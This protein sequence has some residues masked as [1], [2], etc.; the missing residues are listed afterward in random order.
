MGGE[1]ATVRFIGPKGA[2]WIALCLSAP[3]WAQV[4]AVDDVTELRAGSVS[5]ARQ[6]ARQRVDYAFEATAGRTYLIEL[7]QQGL[8]FVLSIEDPRGDARTYGSPLLRDEREI[9]LL[10]DAQ[11]GI[12]RVSVFSEEFS[13]ASGRH[14]IRLS[15]P[16]PGEDTRVW[17]AMSAG[18]AAYRRGGEQGWADAIAA[19][20][21][22]AGLA[23]ESG[24][25]REVAHALFGIAAIEYWYRYAWTRAAELAKEAAQLYADLDQPLLEASALHLRAAALIEEA[26]TVPRTSSAGLAPRARALF[27]EALDL[28]DRVRRTFE[29]RGRSYEAGLAIN[30]VG[31]T[32]YYMGEYAAA[33]ASWDE[34]AR[35]FRRLGEWDKELTALGNQA[36]IAAEQGRLADAIAIFERSLDLLSADHP[37]R[38]LTLDNLAATHYARGDFDDA[39]RTFSAALDLHRRNDDGKGE[40]HALRGIGSTYFALGHLELAT[41]FLERALPLARES[42]DGRNEKSIRGLL[43]NV[44]FLEGEH[45]EALN[46][47]RAALALATA[48]TDAAVVQVLLAKDLV[49]LGRHAAAGAL[50]AEARATAEAAGAKLLVADAL[51][52]SGQARL[53]LGRT[54]EAAAEFRRALAVYR[55]LGVSTKESEA[56]HGIAESAAADGRLDDA[57]RYGNASLVALEAERIRIAAPELRA[58]YAAIRRGYYEA[59]IERLMTLH[60][61]ARGGETDA[62]L[63]AAFETSE[64]SRAR[65]L[66][67]LM[68]ETA[69]DDTATA[70]D[71]SARERARLI[72]R[73]AGLR[74]RRDSLLAAPPTAQTE[75]EVAEAVAEMTVVDNELKVLET[76]LRSKDERSAL[77]PASPLSLDEIQA[78]LD[79]HSFLVQYALGERRSHAWIVTKSA[80]HAVELAPREALESAAR[81]AHDALARYDASASRTEQLEERL[82]SLAEAVLAPVRP[83]LGD[84]GRIVFSADGALQYVPFGV[85]RDTA[86]DGR[87]LIEQYEIAA[88]P[89]VS[90]V[91]SSRAATRPEIAANRVAVIADPV[92]EPDDARL[93]GIRT[94]REPSP[95]NPPAELEPRSALLAEP[96]A[97]LPFAG[98]EASAIAALVPPD[99]RLVLTGVAASRDAVLNADLGLYRFVHFATHGFV[100]S[101]YPSLSGL[102]LSGIDEHGAPRDGFLRLDDIRV[103]R[104]DADVVVL[105]ACETALGREIRGEGLL[106]LTHAFMQAGARSTVASLWQVPDRATAELMSRFYAGMLERGLRPTEALRAAQLEIAAERRWRDPYFW[107]AFVL[108]GDWR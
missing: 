55:E 103:L 61:A 5:S 63:L 70:D 3:C 71:R 17:A 91:L 68:H 69:D 26:T 38:A 97:R 54:L 37:D 73:L 72:E 21:T 15:A 89:S 57:V 20:E 22:A 7:D 52:Q 79:E 9:V 49:A 88:V 56:L 28:F 14:A 78:G 16:T 66:L 18:A 94:S 27:D 2:G 50:A 60:R 31:L 25:H 107:G 86:S 59:Q 81:R 82:D 33:R 13:A 48:P 44:A 65:V 35:L 64:R 106:G 99:D 11:S 24:R 85:L 67:D 36:V 41:A 100:D 32:Y 53:G 96:L 39:L 77:A 4:D 84:G 105:S 1:A 104:L 8:D 102:A 74:H 80:V 10:E 45:E 6:D 98:R 75:T 93:A 34:A 46:H 30:N 19:Y 92:F 83:Y 87:R 43:G 58:H 40:A 12:Y 101:R 47:H 62:H 95:R 108:M 23:R 76:A 51:Q 29:R 90:A 42:G